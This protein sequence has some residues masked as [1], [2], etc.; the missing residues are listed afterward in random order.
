MDSRKYL[1]DLERES[2]EKNLIDRL[3][4]DRRNAVMFLVALHTGARATELLGITW[5]DINIETREVFVKT[6]KRYKRK[7][8]DDDDTANKNRLKSAEKHRRSI[9]IPKYLFDALLKL[10]TKDSIKPFD[11]SYPRLAE[12]W[13][14]YRPVKK[15]FHS[16]R[17]TFAIYAQ[18]RC[19]NV[20]LV[21]KLLGH[22]SIQSTMVYADYIYTS[23]EIRKALRIK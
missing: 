9:P 4:T 21:Q 22:G 2:L 6:L 10:K 20:R 11:L 16:L 17:H 12:L 1:T 5:N 15:P 19:G 23:G 8:S 13:K 3:E 7:D 14:M 18:T